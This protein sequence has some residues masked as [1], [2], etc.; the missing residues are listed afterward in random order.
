MTFFIA[1]L[2]RHEHAEQVRGQVPVVLDPVVDEADHDP[3]RTPHRHDEGLPQEQGQVQREDQPG[4]LHPFVV[5][6]AVEGQNPDEGQ[7]DQKLACP[8]F[9]FALDLSFLP[10]YLVPFSFIAGSHSFVPTVIILISWVVLKS[11]KTAVDVIQ[12]KYF[13]I[14]V[15]KHC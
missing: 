12:I 11:F 1:S 7:A 4:W 6:D 10:F 15:I 8:S 9:L 2:G 13:I 5:Q 14:R 3:E